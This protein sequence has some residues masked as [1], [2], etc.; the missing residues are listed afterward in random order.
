[1]RKHV[2][3]RS[4]VFVLSCMA[5]ALSSVGILAHEEIEAHDKLSAAEHV[6]AIDRGGVLYDSWYGAL[7]KEAP[8]E[9]HP[10]YPKAGKQKGATTWRCKECHGWDYKGASG[11]YG[12]GGRYTGIRGI[13]NMTY[14]SEN[15]IV[16][17]LKDK[18]HGFGRLIPEKDM[19]ALAH[20]VAHGQI[21]V[22]IYID[23][24]TKKAKGNPA[25]GERIFQTTCA[26]CHGSDGKLIN[27]KTPPEVEYIGTV[28]NENPWE[29][30]HKIRMGQPGVP[31]ISM[32]AFEVQDHVDI[33]AYA[34]TLPKK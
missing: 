28:A 14:A 31:M 32:L 11:V 6:V 15:A 22:D 1:M 27:F 30:L 10:A 4:V 8:K 33:L 13:R 17:I 29:T 7:G 19:E 34:Q 16:A 23:R 2:L 25:R 3:K 21:D 24:A 5:A 12:K 9:T 20:F 18:T 26:R